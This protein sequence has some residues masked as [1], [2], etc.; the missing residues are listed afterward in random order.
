LMGIDFFRRTVEIEKKYMRQGMNI[1]NTLQTNGVLLDEEWCRF[2]RANNFL[3]GISVD[4][5]RHLHDAFRRDKGGK[6]VFDKVV[7]A[8]RLMQ[9]HQVEFNILCTVNAA[10][11]REPLEVYRFF[12]D[13]LEARY[14]QLIPI[15]ERD[16]ETG[17]QEGSCVTD[18]SVNPEQWGRFLIEIFDEWV[19]KDVGNMFVLHFDN[20]LASYV[21]GRSNVCI[22]SPTCGEAVAL[23]HNGDVYSCDHFVEPKYL[24]GNIRQNSLNEL[25]NSERQRK[26]GRDKS[27]DLPKYCRECEWLFTCH[28]ECPKNR[29]LMT[30]DGEK[31]LNWLCAGMKAFFSH[32]KRHMELMA[33]YLHMGQPASLIMD[34]VIKTEET[35][36]KRYASVGRNDPC[37]CGSRLKFKKCCGRA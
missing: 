32:T 4:G 8:V 7:R 14:I 36:R 12:R 23:E 27:S 34:A 6:P 11:S 29:V 3:V 1:E 9:E 28:G 31:G 24:L 13:E 17:N 30:P 25:V 10:N 33:Q 37:P 21:H 15:V 5:P 20:V 2:L 16:N 18:R 35:G 19:A 22:L 26:F